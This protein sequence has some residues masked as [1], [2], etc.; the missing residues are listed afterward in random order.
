VVAFVII[1]PALD[2]LA[3]ES[4]AAQS[5]AQYRPIGSSWHDSKSALDDE[6]NRTTA[7]PL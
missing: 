6:E 7:P 2:A 1:S 5:N 4:L 3:F